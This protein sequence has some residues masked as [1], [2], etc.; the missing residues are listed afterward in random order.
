MR[1]SKKILWIL[2][3]NQKNIKTYNFISIL[4]K[5]ERALRDG[6]FSAVFL[7]L[8]FDLTHFIFF[9]ST[10]FDVFI[11]MLGLWQHSIENINFVTGCKTLCMTRKKEMQG[12]VARIKSRYTYKHYIKS[13]IF[14]KKKFDLKQIYQILWA[15]FVKMLSCLIYIR[16]DN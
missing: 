13:L 11:K 16:N 4:R 6:A 1:L 2:F 7:N 10:F 3:H 9:F 14:V 12:M 5:T 15:F 8:D